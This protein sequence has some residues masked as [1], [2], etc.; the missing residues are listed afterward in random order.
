MVQMLPHVRKQLQDLKKIPYGQI[1]KHSAVIVEIP[2]GQL[3]P[4]D[5]ARS[6]YVVTNAF[7]ELTHKQQIIVKVIH[8]S[9]DEIKKILDNKDLTRDKLIKEVKKIVLDHPPVDGE[10]S[11]ES[12]SS[13]SKES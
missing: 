7:T 4:H 10:H 3:S 2:I 6:L 8:E 9:Q 13:E 11:S 1:K 5:L 12:S